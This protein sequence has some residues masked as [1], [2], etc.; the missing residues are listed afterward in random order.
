V[1]DRP[2]PIPTGDSP[3][4]IRAS[5]IRP[6]SQPPSGHRSDRPSPIPTGDSPTPI[7]ASGIWPPSQP[8]SGHRSR[9]AALR[10]RDR[11]GGHR[12]RGL[13]CTSASAEAPTGAVASPTP[14]RERDRRGAF[15]PCVP[16]AERD[17]RP[18]PRLPLRPAAE[19]DRSRDRLCALPPRAPALRQGGNRGA[20][21][22]A[23]RPTDRRGDGGAAPCS[24]PTSRIGSFPSSPTTFVSVCPCSCCH[25]RRP[26]RV[27]HHFYGWELESNRQ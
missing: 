20:T 14:L 17:R 11:S 21:S 15:A 16:A 13:P 9:R 23:T 2:S 18:E 6:P 8:P 25:Y 12:S 27:G 3:T 4:P 22:M 10:E 5:G 19:R 26:T 24:S 1:A 7:R